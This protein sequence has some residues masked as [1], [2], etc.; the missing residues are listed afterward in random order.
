MR[1]YSAQGPDGRIYEF[2]GPDGISEQA[3]LAAVRRQIASQ[4]PAP[5]PQSGFIAASKAGIA[6]LKS[7]IASLA[8]RTGLMDEAAANKY[9]KEQEEYRQRPFKPTETFGEAPVTKTLELFGGSLPYMAAPIAAGVGALALPGAAIAAPIAAGLTSAAQ[10]TG[11]NLSRQMAEGKTLGETELGSAFAASI[12]QAALD[13]FAFRLLPG[14]RKIFAAAGKEVPEKV[15]LDATKQS[16]GKVTADYTLA[17]GK[18]AGMEGL[19]E[20]G[21]QVLERLQAG[22]AI[23]D[24]KA[25]SEYFDSFIGGAVLGGVIAPGGRY[26]ERAGEQGKQRTA[27]QAESKRLADEARGIQAAEDAKAQELLAAGQ[28]RE[29]AMERARNMPGFTGLTDPN[30]ELL[31]AARDQ[32]EAEAAAL[33]Q[34][35]VTKINEVEAT[36]YHADPLENQRRK[37]AELAKLGEMPEVQEA[38]PPIEVITPEQQAQQRAV[39][40]QGRMAEMPG[41]TGG[42]GGINELMMRN[43]RESQADQ[44]RQQKVD[45]Q[46]KVDE[47]R[48]TNYSSDPTQN[49]MLQQK[50]FEKLGFM[51]YVP[52]ENQLGMVPE[53]APPATP[54]A[55][56]PKQISTAQL[57]I[58]EAPVV[59]A[60]KPIEPAKPPAPPDV[61]EVIDYRE[62]QDA[63]DAA[64][65]QE[66]ISKF[67]GSRILAPEEWAAIGVAP[68]AEKV[69]IDRISNPDNI[70]INAEPITGGGKPFATRAEAIEVKNNFKPADAAKDAR[71]VKLDDYMVIKGK[72]GYVLTPKVAQDYARQKKAGRRLTGVS[73]D[74]REYMSS[75]EAIVSNGGLRPEIANE[76]SFMGSNPRIGGKFLFRKDGMTLEQTGDFLRESGYPVGEKFYHSEVL[77]L[78]ENPKLTADGYA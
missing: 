41:F 29:A 71:G 76:T 68:K 58:T 35:R 21:Q 66:K 61:Q 62:Q 14:I 32:R 65:A 67:S 47:I 13:V 44:E 16:V 22:L 31:S 25:R 49:V 42:P 52:I 73:T 17:T 12:P 19:T 56:A 45:L 23:N 7:D 46:A 3:V 48:N 27:Q 1:I 50:E 51:P 5:N 18:A 55:P 63:I 74:G 24:E 39:E 78:V 72:E 4:P 11:S 2:E 34:A 69:V 15:L 40:T 36:I 59:A 64:A 8:G 33:E 53:G 10:F 77:D 38:A 57:P 26:I 9:I 70:G 60:P 28:R 6:S 75:L 30:V 37:T 54:K 20:A 43:V